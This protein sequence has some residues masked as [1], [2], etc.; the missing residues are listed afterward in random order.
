MLCAGVVH[1]DLSPYNVLL[2]ADGPVIIDF[3]QAI[4]PSK[5]LNSRRFLLRD[6]DNLH[7]FLARFV[8]DGRR[9]PYA[10][11]MWAQ[12]ES[13][14]L[15]PDTVLRGQ[16]RASQK[17]ADTKELLEFIGE[18]K[19]DAQRRGGASRRSASATSPRPRRVE[20]IVV[21][22]KASG[23]KS[24][25]NRGRRGPPANGSA[26]HNRQPRGGARVTEAQRPPQASPA[27]PGRGVRNGS[28]AGPASSEAGPRDGGV[29][30]APR[31]K[32]RRRR[33][34]PPGGSAPAPSPVPVSQGL[35]PARRR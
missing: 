6:V 29:C 9:K 1:G 32:R 24:T 25:S 35:R 21:N 28:A 16:Y 18:V 2:G 10:E 15:K 11:E 20:V 23:A 31:A 7:R 30:P 12:Y 33:R 5:N 8:P 13:N 19:Q 4:D 26:A 22:R 17:K 14:Q 3:P 27:N 34:R